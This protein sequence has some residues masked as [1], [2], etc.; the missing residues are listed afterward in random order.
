M[1]LFKGIYRR[2]NAV[3]LTQKE[4]KNWFSKIDYHLMQAKYF[5]PSLSYHLSLRP[6]CY[7][8]L[9]CRLRQVLLYAFNRRFHVRFGQQ[10]F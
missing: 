6:L 10:A 5:R 3:N 2:K 9:K 8:F 7:L 1:K 4:D